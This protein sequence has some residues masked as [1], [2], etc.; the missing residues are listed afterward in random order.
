MLKKRKHVKELKYMRNENK[1]VEHTSSDMHKKKL[2]NEPMEAYS[3]RS[4]SPLRGKDNTMRVTRKGKLK[5]E[6]VTDNQL[7]SLKIAWNRNSDATPTPSNKKTRPNIKIKD[8][9]GQGE[10]GMTI[11]IKSWNLLLLHNKSLNDN[12]QSWL[13][14]PELSH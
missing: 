4:W 2:L 11:N 10:D 3:N 14:L 7:Y 1:S 6:L 5:K 12:A 8:S 9:W 13:W